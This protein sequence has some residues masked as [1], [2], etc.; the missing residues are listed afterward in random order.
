MG[1]GFDKED[2]A[3]ESPADTARFVSYSVSNSSTTIDNTC[4]RNVFDDL[5]RDEPEGLNLCEDFIDDLLMVH[6]LTQLVP[7][8]SQ[9]SAIMQPCTCALTI[10]N[11]NGIG[12]QRYVFCYK[13]IHIGRETLSIYREKEQS[14]ECCLEDQGPQLQKSVFMP[15]L[16]VN[17]SE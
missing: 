14:G 7:G 15:Q 13:K 6:K 1:L 9:R 17:N 5:L 3:P 11:N 2:E 10:E 16:V 4:G 8:A 12:V